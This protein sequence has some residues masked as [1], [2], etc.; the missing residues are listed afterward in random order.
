M[1]ENANVFDFEL[2]EED[3]KRIDALNQNERVGLDPNNFNFN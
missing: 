3:M 1:I 2:M